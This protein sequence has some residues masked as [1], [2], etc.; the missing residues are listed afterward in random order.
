VPELDGVPP[1]LVAFLID[2]FAQL[3]AKLESRFDVLDDEIKALSSRVDDT[4]K[5]IRKLRRAS[6][7]DAGNMSQL[8]SSSP[9][10]SGR[11]SDSLTMRP[12]AK[13]VRI[14]LFYLIPSEN[15]LPLHCYGLWSDTNPKICPDCCLLAQAP[16]RPSEIAINLAE[17]LDPYG[18]SDLSSPGTPKKSVLRVQIEEIQYSPEQLE[19]VA[20]GAK[21]L[22]HYLR[23]AIEVR[24][25]ASMSTS[26]HF[27]LYDNP[28]VLISSEVGVGSGDPPNPLSN[29]QFLTHS[30]SG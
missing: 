28:H 7:H 16:T 9:I 26:M 13:A 19:K 18:G 25:L 14:M 1:A 5:S 4:Q 24:K 12:R 20:Q 22:Q 17:R 2:R 30:A 8:G 21:T 29:V 11:S 6:S 23:T 27:T 10:L 15:P 3:E